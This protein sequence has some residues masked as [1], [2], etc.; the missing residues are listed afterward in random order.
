MKSGALLGRSED[1]HHTMRLCSAG[2]QLAA[3]IL[4]LQHLILLLWLCWLRGT[5]RGCQLR[6]GTGWALC[7]DTADTAWAGGG[8]GVETRGAKASDVFTALCIGLPRWVP[9]GAQSMTCFG[10]CPR[11]SQERHTAVRVGIATMAVWL[12]RQRE[13]VFT[14]GRA[15]F[16]VCSGRDSV[17]IS[18]DDLYVP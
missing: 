16:S 9:W 1:G 14:E 5:G 3:F 18:T 7:A 6:G 8:A 15:V 17:R 4:Y 2:D 12:S 10:G 11:G 13:T